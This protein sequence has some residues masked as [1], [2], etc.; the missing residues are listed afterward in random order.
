MKVTNITSYNISLING[1]TIKVNQSV[2]LENPESNVIK[3]IKKLEEDD[4]LIV[5]ML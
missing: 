4:I 3:Q 2:I 1:V 5:E